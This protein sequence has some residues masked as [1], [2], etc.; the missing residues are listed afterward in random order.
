MVI[1]QSIRNVDASVT[2]SVVCRL[3]SG[4]LQQTLA[5]AESLCVDLAIQPIARI[6]QYFSPAVESNGLSSLLE[7]RDIG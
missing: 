1:S 7:L 5:S 2:T 3:E 4:R 6:A